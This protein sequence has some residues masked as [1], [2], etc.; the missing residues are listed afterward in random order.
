MKDR[1]FIEYLKTNCVGK[2]NRQR[3]IDIQKAIGISPRSI[4]HEVS[5]VRNHP[6]EFDFVICSSTHDGGYWIAI[7]GKEMKET[8]KLLVTQAV[9]QLKS[10]RKMMDALNSNGQLLF[11]EEER[12]EMK[13]IFGYIDSL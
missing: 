11:T 4:R 2:E 12:I 10:A 1:L 7:D 6:E 3:A 8:I 5:Y 9:T 13:N